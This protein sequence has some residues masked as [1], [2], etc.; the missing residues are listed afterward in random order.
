MATQPKTK[1]SAKGTRTCKKPKPSSL[2]S[3][4]RSAGPRSGRSAPSKSSLQKL[5]NEKWSEEFPARIRFLI[6][7]CGLINKRGDVDYKRIAKVLGVSV[8]GLRRWKNPLDDYYK[9]A[10]AEAV[11]A[12]VAELDAG[13]IHR[14]LIDLA[15]PHVVVKRTRALKSTGIKPPPKSWSKNDLLTFARIKLGI[16]LDPDLSKIEIR[17]RIEGACE[18]TGAEKLVTVREERTTEVDVGAA[19]YVLSNIGDKDK[20]WKVKE[21]REHELGDEELTKVLSLI[22]GSTKGLPRKEACQPGS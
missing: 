15:K 8:Q 11:A 19:K 3:A 14:G 21:T 22:D 6:C 4:G 20:R 9:P 7:E 17:L 18:K 12:A 2:Q 13:H 5:N 10:L 1:G 16:E